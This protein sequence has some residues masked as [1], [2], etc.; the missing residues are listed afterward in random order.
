MY[1]P[2]KRT[3]CHVPLLINISPARGKRWWQL[4]QTKKKHRNCTRPN[5][6]QKRTAD[7]Q[8]NAVCQLFIYRL[9]ATG[10]DI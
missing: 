1:M 6:A 7:P 5:I 9:G 2:Y 10:Y 8:F 4:Y 3:A